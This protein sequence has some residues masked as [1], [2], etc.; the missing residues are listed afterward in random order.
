MPFGL[1]KA[2]LRFRGFADKVLKP[3]SDV[4]RAY[5]D[6]FLNHTDTFMGACVGFER[7]LTELREAT[8]MA[9]FSKCRFMMRETPYLGFLLTKEGVK[10]NPTKTVAI[11]SLQ[12]QLM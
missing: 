7:V 1:V 3:N 9:S 4:C 11:R 12:G 10:I 6:D 8:L 5:L 2:V